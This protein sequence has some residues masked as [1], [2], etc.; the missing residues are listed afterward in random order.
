MDKQEF[1][2]LIW[3]SEFFNKKISR[4]NINKA[5]EIEN[6]YSSISRFNGDLVYLFSKEK[7]A[8]QLN[9]HF[10]LADKKV[11][12]RKK[13][14]SEQELFNDN[15]VE[16][17]TTLTKELL[18]LA[19][20]S[21]HHSRFK[22]DNSLN[23]KFNEL[24]RIW[25]EKSINRELASEVFVYKIEQKE[26]AFVTIKKNGDSA[27]IGLLA[28]NSSY[29]GKNI[30]SLLISAIE[31]WCFKNNISTL[32]VATQLDNIQACNFYKKNGFDIKEV[33]YIYHYY[34]K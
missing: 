26:I 7:L 19:F 28:V 5:T 16:S 12:F 30:G 29:H 2:S 23:S 31:N 24:Y 33:D 17:S 14:V 21:G 20:L 34:K 8:I 10:F 9:A 13:I 27:N 11:V 4:F 22:L 15:H 18:E 32:D 3:D 1:L 6:F 25:L